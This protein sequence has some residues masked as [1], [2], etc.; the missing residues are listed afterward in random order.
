MVGDLTSKQRGCYVMEG[1][2]YTSYED[3]SETSRKATDEEV[4]LADALQRVTDELRG[5]SRELAIERRAAQR[6]AAEPCPTH[7]AEH[8]QRDTLP[9][10]WCVIDELKQ[11]R[12]TLQTTVEYFNAQLRRLALVVQ[13]DGDTAEAIVSKAIELFAEMPSEPPLDA[14]YCPF[15]HKPCEPIDL[16]EETSE[17]KEAPRN[18]RAVLH[19]CNCGHSWREHQTPGTE[20]AVED[21]PCGYYREIERLE[22]APP[23]DPGPVQ[24]FEPN[25]PERGFATMCANCGQTFGKHIAQ[26]HHGNSSVCPVHETGD[27]R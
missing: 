9:C 27:G 1:V 21:C 8:R 22:F 23:A 19:A 18:D 2:T 13:K 10:P 15:N 7:A 6:A 11:G 12:N 17:T 25:G 4:L 16:A 26:D 20:C 14:R 5:C 3:G 24:T